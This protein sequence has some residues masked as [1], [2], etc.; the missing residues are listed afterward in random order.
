M[1]GDAAHTHPP[2]GG[3]GLNNGL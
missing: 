2:Y 1:A 3:F